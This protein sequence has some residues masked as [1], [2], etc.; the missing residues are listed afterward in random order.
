MRYFNFVQKT[1]DIVYFK[2]SRIRQHSHDAGTRRKKRESFRGNRAI[3]RA[4]HC[5]SIDRRQ[6]KRRRKN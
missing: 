5:P 4:R 3:K 2:I 1:E 6:A